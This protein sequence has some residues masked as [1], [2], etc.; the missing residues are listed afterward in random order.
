MYENA[1]H[2]AA[3]RA[4]EYVRP[5]TVLGL[6]SGTTSTKFVQLLAERFPAK[7]SVSCICTSSN[8]KS[9]A[10]KLGL[11]LL[12][13]TSFAEADLT[14]D[15]ADE[16]TLSLELI[17]GGGGAL[18][19][20]RIVAAASK[21]HITMVDESKVHQPLGTFPL[22]IEIAPYASNVTT[23]WVREKIETLGLTIEHAAVRKHANGNFITDNGNFMLDVKVARIDDPATLSAAL[24]N[25]TGVVDHGIFLGLTDMLIVARNDGHIDE[26]RLPKTN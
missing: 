18:M 22:P 7:D 6:G 1:K 13:E 4:L 20:E 23:R 15:G 8:I 26:Y 14:V 5:N 19:R 9:L 2:H 11:N 3:A 12:D 25:V 10:Q 17:K 21:F 24:Y 16:A